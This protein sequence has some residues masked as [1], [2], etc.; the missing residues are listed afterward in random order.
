MFIENECLWEFVVCL[1]YVTC[2]WMR[3]TYATVLNFWV[4]AGSLRTL[5]QIASRQICAIAKTFI[6][7]RALIDI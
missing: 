2:V 1:A 6:P 3:W 4:A 5:A 7:N